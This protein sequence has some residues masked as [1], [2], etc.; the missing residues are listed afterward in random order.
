M[1]VSPLGEPGK[2]IINDN[3]SAGKAGVGPTCRA[4]EEE[5]VLPCATSLQGARASPKGVC[6]DEEGRGTFQQEALRMQRQRLV[7]RVQM[8]VSV[9]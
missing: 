8:S 1:A 5:Q 4:A 3:K 7:K 9:A 6:R 2:L